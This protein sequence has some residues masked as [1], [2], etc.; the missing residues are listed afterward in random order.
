M[1]EELSKAVQTVAVPSDVTSRDSSM[2]CVLCYV[3]SSHI[4]GSEA[5]CRVSIKPP[6]NSDADRSS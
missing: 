6:D 1:G 2:V 3:G 5:R 4:A